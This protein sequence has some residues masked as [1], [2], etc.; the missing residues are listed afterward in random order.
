MFPSLQ[1]SSPTP[2]PTDAMSHLMLVVIHFVNAT[3]SILVQSLTI[4]IQ[5]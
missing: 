1:A 4:E 3:D 5:I 2:T